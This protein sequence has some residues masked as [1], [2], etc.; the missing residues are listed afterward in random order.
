ML[1]TNFVILDT[2]VRIPQNIQ[3]EDEVVC[4]FMINPDE[5]TWQPSNCRCGGM[6]SITL[7]P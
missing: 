1:E 2:N 4:Y 3:T 7:N 5:Y 6:E